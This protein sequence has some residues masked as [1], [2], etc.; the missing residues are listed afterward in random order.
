MLR[1]VLPFKVGG[2]AGDLGGFLAGPSAQ[3][4]RTMD[5]VRREVPKAVDDTNVL[6][7]RFTA[8]VKQLSEAGIYPVMPKPV[9]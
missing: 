5:E 3:N 1:E 2:L 7:A 8:F 6:V 9:K 4:L